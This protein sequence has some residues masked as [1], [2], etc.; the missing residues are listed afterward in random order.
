MGVYRRNRGGIW[1]S[2]TAIERAII[3]LDAYKDLYK[4]N[5]DD[6]IVLER[7]C[8][9]LELFYSSF[10][11]PPFQRHKV[12]KNGLKNLFLTFQ[13]DLRTGGPNA[14]LRHTWGCIKAFFSFC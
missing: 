2:H 1:W 9:W 13:H 5:R 11:L 10:V 12:T 8:E 6:C 3:R 7:Y 4:Y 14:M